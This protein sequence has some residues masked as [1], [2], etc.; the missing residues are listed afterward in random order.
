MCHML[1]TCKQVQSKRQIVRKTDTCTEQNVY[2][3]RGYGRVK[4]RVRATLNEGENG[5][6]IK[7]FE[8]IA[9]NEKKIGAALW[10][11]LTLAAFTFRSDVH[12][13]DAELVS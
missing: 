13:D 10:S 4:V 6:E 9:R 8:M 7:V 1:Y 12:M 2:T 5:C 11:A 3:T